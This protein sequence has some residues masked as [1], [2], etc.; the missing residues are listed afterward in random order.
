MRC[1]LVFPS[2]HAE[3]V[4]SKEFADSQLTLWQPTGL[5]Y[6]AAALEKAGH[7]V[8]LMDGAFFTREQIRTAVREFRPGFVGVYSNLPLIEITRLTTDDVKA[9]DPS[10]VTGIGGPTASGLREQ[11]YDRIASVDLIF[12]G[13]GE[14]AAPQAVACLESGEDLGS[15]ESL[16]FRRDGVV[17]KNRD[18]APIEDLDALP[19]PA[20]HL[21]GDLKKYVPAPSTY[22]RLPIVTII[23]SR[24]CTSRCIYCYQMF[25][26]RRIRYRSAQNIVDEM[27]H[28]IDAYGVKEV[29]FF[30][31]NF[32]GDY[33]RVREICDLILARKLK[34]AWYCNSRV[35]S[36]DFALMKRM[37]QA[38]C[39]CVLFGVE[40][41][42]QKN[43]NVLR[44]HQTVDQVRKA[45]REAKEAGLE[46]Y[47]P[48]I[49]GIPGETYEEALESVNFA[50]E[51][52]AHYVNFHTMAPFAGTELY[53][54]VERYGTLTGNEANYNFEQAGFVP[55]TLTREQIFELRKLAFRRFYMRPSYMIKRL[56]KTRTRADLRTLMTGAKSLY[57]LAVRGEAFRF[58]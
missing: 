28:C 15:V 58:K 35:D 31:D 48:F 7:E 44:K 6:V 22:K 10:I 14:Y 12:T 49:I 5:M 16:I 19:Y 4:F 17:V 55:R 9:I 1:L 45:V 23:S 43:L 21:L 32:C 13:E 25:S 56:L 11:L 42:V 50:M 40:S 27:Q 53:D 47:T 36:V 3:D 33:D 54:K 37:Q 26:E 18:A 41:G 52:D 2:W 34:I 57:Y 39:W 30:D 29:R 20:R 51:L 8:R 46:V 24:G 38:G